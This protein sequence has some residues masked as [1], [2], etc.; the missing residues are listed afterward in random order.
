VFSLIIENSA[1]AAPS[2]GDLDSWASAHGLTHPIL[3]D[4]GGAFSWNY[5][6]TESGG[7]FGLPSLQLI[8]PGMEVLAVNES[9]ISISL[10]EAHL[11]E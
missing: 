8:G 5:I 10:I 6:S 3:A 1:S 9:D 2:V 4:P 7:S 11:P